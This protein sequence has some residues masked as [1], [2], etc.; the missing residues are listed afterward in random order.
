MLNLKL[1]RIKK[2]FTLMQLAE[3]S[4]INYN[5]INSWELGKHSPSKEKLEVIAKVLECNV[6]DLI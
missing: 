4:N 5:S 2:G 1:M 3:K 6:T